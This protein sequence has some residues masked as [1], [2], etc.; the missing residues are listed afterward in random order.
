VRRAASRWLAAVAAVF[1]LLCAYSCAVPLGPGYHVEKETVDLTFVAQ[2]Q[3]R[4]HF[5]GR[6]RLENVGNAPL[7]SLDVT[8]PQK[9]LL[10]RENLH[11]T[12]DGKDAAGEELDTDSAA[13]MAAFHLRFEPSWRPGDTKDMEIAF[14]MT[15]GGDGR[16]V[17]AADAFAFDGAYWF[18]AFQ[19]PK[20]IFAKGEQRAEPTDLRVVLPKDFLAVASGQPTSQKTHGDTVEYRFRLRA[21]IDTPIVVAGR[22]KQQLAKSKGTAVYFW[23]FQ[24]LPEDAVKT[25][26]EQ[27]A[28]AAQFFDSN[29][30]PRARGE[31][32]LW[33]VELPQNVT[34]SFP[35][36]IL[37]DK[38][39][40]SQ[41]VGRGQVSPAEIGL[42][43]DTWLQWMASPDP[44]RSIV[45]A[46]L[47]TYMVNAF[48][49]SRQ[50]ASYRQMKITEYLG[51]Y[52]ALHARAV[53]KPIAQITSAESPGQVNMAVNKS[54]LFLYALEDSCGQA[55]FRKG[56]G[57]MLS[58]LR[59]GEYG[60][61]DLR[62][63]LN[64][65]CAQTADVDGLF[66]AWLYETGIPANFRERYPTAVAAEQAK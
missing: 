46:S 48:Y 8:V 34:G 17:M 1:P 56:V 29:F 20:K 63:G 43:S 41:T 7:T 32:P 16:T 19:A 60:Y 51:Q 31:S 36:M 47:G 57:H 40:L 18:P 15:A 53:E 14:D 50:G 61:E 35:S 55:P 22:Y 65:E 37:L 54:D 3:P 58:S 6:Y 30:T 25:T 11:V 28:A 52:D 23:T 59:G 39:L 13:K 26:G 62:A 2:P 24:G 42:L 49:E 27:I 4:L 64:I 33:V 9:D 44:A 10:G 5:Q 66:R 12:A 45:P 21:I 38:N